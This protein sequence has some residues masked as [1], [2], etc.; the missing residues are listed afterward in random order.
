MRITIIKQS[1]VETLNIMN[2]LKIDNQYMVLDEYNGYSTI[3][4]YSKKYD[5]F[6]IANVKTENLDDSL[7]ISNVETD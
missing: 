6:H 7:K 5:N 1:Q 4:Q 2:T 3:C